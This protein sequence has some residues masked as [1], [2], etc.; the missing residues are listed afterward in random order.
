MK[1]LLL[2]A[3]ITLSIHVIAQTNTFPT[4][5]NVGIGTTNPQV[6]LHLFSNG[7][8]L[9][10]IEG[11]NPYIHAGLMFTDGAQQ[12]A[13]KVKQWAIWAG[14]DGGTWLSGLGF[15]RYDAVNPCAGGICDISLFLHDNG[16][17][18]IGTGAPR[19]RLEVAGPSLFD[20]DM[21]TWQNGGIF[22]SGNGSYSAGIYGRNAGNDLVFNS[23][24]A[25]KM[26]ISNNGNLGIGTQNP[27][28][29][30][31]V[32]GKIH[33]EEVIIDLG[34]PADYVFKPN[35]KL[36]PLHQVEQFVKTNSHLPEIPSANEITKNG[37]S[38]GEM[39]NKLLQKIE[40]F[41]LYAIQQNK[42]IVEQDKKNKEMEFEL[43]ALKKIV[44]NDIV[45]RK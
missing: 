23:G 3:I 7:Q 29:K 17:V 37:L 45:K 32:K 6:S 39:Q 12:T 15:H 20:S 4:S 43:D 19:Q 41:T 26:R 22:F 8:T 5:G 28:Q 24:G 16:N 2:I 36:M 10:N 34:V 31:T 44:E 33:A 9:Q 13:G 35:Y 40:E 42:K 14:T 21:F 38:M 25:E 18:G 11:S 1:N 30:L 27:D